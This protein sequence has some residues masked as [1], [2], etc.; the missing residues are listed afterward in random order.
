M[1]ITALHIEA[2]RCRFSDGKNLPKQHG[3]KL[4]KILTGLLCGIGLPFVASF[5]DETQPVFVPEKGN[6][7]YVSA[8]CYGIKGNGP[9]D[10]FLFADEFAFK[11]SGI[12]YGATVGYEMNKLM[13][14]TMNFEFSYLKGDPDASRSELY[15]EDQVY[16]SFTYRYDIKKV[17]LSASFTP[18][19]LKFLS[20]GVALVH[21]DTCVSL[22][23]RS[24]FTD[25]SDLYK[26]NYSTACTSTDMLVTAA[27]RYSDF[28]LIN[29]SVCTLSLI[30]SAKIGVGYSFRSCDDKLSYDLYY[31]DSDSDSDYHMSGSMDISDMGQE[32]GAPGD[33]PIYE[34]EASVGLVYE[35]G[36]CA[37]SILGGY[38]YESD[39]DD[40]RNYFEGF[41][42]KLE[43]K[44]SL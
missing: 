30:P 6:S 28:H 35:K 43:F 21:Y 32:I 1:K 8:D 36:K 19:C 4:Y 13:A 39:L 23:Y 18:D 26:L 17:R 42:G 25:E 9:L 31:S 12:L 24:G 40:H 44:Y 7:F 3:M 34:C 22:D 37:A 10:G 2:V 38:R 20:L 14:G 15:S 16:E 5:G 33:A 27:V 11:P 29:N 41:Y